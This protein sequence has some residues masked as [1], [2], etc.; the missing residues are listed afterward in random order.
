MTNISQ[1]DFERTDLRKQPRTDEEPDAKSY[2][3]EARGFI[4]RDKLV[5]A[6]AVCILVITLF[7]VFAPMKSTFAFD[8]VDMS[9]INISPGGAHPFGT[10]TLGRDLWS[11]VWVGTRVSLII[12]VA[13][14]ILPQIIGFVVGCVAGYS[15]GWV[16]MVIMGIV[17]VGV[18]VP[19]L[20]YVTLASLWLDSSLLAVVFA[21]AVSSW[22][23]TARMVRGRIMQYRNREFVLAAQL[24][25]ASAFRLITRHI[26]PN[27]LG[28][29]LVSVVAALPTAIFLEAYLSFIGLGIVSPMTSLGQLCKT[30][31]SIFRLYPYQLFIP[32]AVISLLIL[33]FYILGNCVRDALD[34][35][36]RQMRS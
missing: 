11:R 14:A 23:D 36:M 17:D 10:D 29:I 30:G 24:Q 34:P 16:D 19:S 32:G 9:N 22:M 18:C 25:G 7:A 5:L 13:G 1:Q 12:G 8:M 35:H 21:I 6:S 31:S 28:H 20:V 26:L 15:G 3:R 2:W 33:A 27:I 4:F